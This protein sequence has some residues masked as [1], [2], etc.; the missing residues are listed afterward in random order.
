MGGR[1]QRRENLGVIGDA[2][3]VFY[4]ARGGM[5]TVD[6]I[7]PGVV[8]DPIPD[9]VLLRLLHLVPAHVWNFESLRCINGWIREAHDLAGK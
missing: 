6:E 1:K 2:D 4:L 9:G 7:K 5:V 3:G 8:G